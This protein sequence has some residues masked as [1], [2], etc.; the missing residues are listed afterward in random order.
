MKHQGRKRL[1]VGLCLPFIL[2][3]GFS[4]NSTL[5]EIS[6]QELQRHQ[7][8]HLQALVIDENNLAYLNLVP[9]DGAINTSETEAIGIETKAEIQFNKLKLEGI[10]FGKIKPKLIFLLLLPYLINLLFYWFIFYIILRF[11]LAGAFVD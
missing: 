8:K 1:I 4:L 3:S 11:I 5:Q 2:V 9:S 7:E 10:L 6:Q